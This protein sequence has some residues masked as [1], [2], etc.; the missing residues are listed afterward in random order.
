MERQALLRRC[1]AYHK[2]KWPKALWTG[3]MLFEGN[4]ITIEE[5]NKVAR[6]FKPTMKV[7]E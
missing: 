7:S 3:I 2:Y 5:F 1:C 6:L 4:S